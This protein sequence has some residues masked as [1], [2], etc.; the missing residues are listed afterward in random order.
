MTQCVVIATPTPA[1]YDSCFN[2]FT[3]NTNTQ[4][5]ELKLRTAVI[6]LITCGQFA[7]ERLKFAF[8][9]VCSVINEKKK[10]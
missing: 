5:T 10:T 7:L 1:R 6:E 9:D 3:I 2:P 8:T 4:S